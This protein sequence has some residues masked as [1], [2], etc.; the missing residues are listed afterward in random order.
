MRHENVPLVRL[1]AVGGLKRY[2]GGEDERSLPLEKGAR[3]ADLV[4]QSGVPPGELGFALRNGT[5]ARPED[6]LEDGDMV[7]IFPVAGGGESKT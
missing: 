4:F 3:L 2:L 6:I 7:E 1:R 5:R